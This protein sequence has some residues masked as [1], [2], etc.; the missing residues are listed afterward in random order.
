MK[1]IAPVVFSLS[2]LVAAAVCLGFGA[3][4]LV[5]ASGSRPPN[6]LRLFGALILIAGLAT[7]R[8][9]VEVSQHLLDPMSA[10]SGALLR[11]LGTVTIALGCIFVWALSPRQHMPRR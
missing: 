5:A 7:P 10:G 6:P 11:V 4:L 1:A 3:A 2:L 9:G 8:Y